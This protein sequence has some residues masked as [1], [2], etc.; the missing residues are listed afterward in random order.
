MK[1]EYVKGDI[2]KS[3]HRF[4]LHGCNAQGVMG[5][6]FAKLVKEKHPFAYKNYLYVH[7][8]RGLK[9]GEVIIVRCKGRVIIHA[10]TQQYYG[11]DGKRYVSYD[12]VANA[13]AAI[14]ENLYGNT[15]AMPKI[16]SGLAGGDWNVIAAIIETELKSVKPIVYEL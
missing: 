7:Q 6:G 13:M 8:T 10:I 2:F 1:I 12:A 3:E 16:G 5:A 9:L 4:I 15:V 11:S 14:E